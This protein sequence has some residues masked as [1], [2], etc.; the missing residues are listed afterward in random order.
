MV[1][2]RAK[3]SLML[4]MILIAAASVAGC[5]A[6]SKVATKAPPEGG[7]VRVYEVFGMDCPGCHGGLEKLVNALPGVTG[8]RASWEE[9]AI[10]VYVGQGVDL[11]DTTIAAA[12]KKANFTPGERLR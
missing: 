5:G 3:S 11:D 12:V 10:T 6:K 7:E 9:K 1:H 2:L 8:S 4:V